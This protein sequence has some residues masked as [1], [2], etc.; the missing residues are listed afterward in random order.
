MAFPR[1]VRPHIGGIARPDQRIRIG[2][3]PKCTNTPERLSAARPP[4]RRTCMS[5]PAA[6]APL[7]FFDSGLGGLTVLGPT[8]ALLPT[9]PIV[10]SRL[11]RPALRSEEHTS[12]LK[13]LMRNSYDLFCLQKKNNISHTQK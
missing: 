11:C 1:L 2:W 12:E 10:S 4:A 13:S 8:R 7:L 6:Q 3:P 9:A 5:S